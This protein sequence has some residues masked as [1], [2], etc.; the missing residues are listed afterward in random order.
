MRALRRHFG[1]F[2]CAHWFALAALRYGFCSAKF[3]W[4]GCQKTGGRGNGMGKV[5]CIN[6]SRY[7]M[8]CGLIT[9]VHKLYSFCARCSRAGLQYLL[10]LDFL[11]FASAP[12]WLDTEHIAISRQ[13]RLNS[14]WH[15]QG[16]VSSGPE[17][18]IDLPQCLLK[19]MGSLILC[20]CTFTHHKQAGLSSRSIGDPTLP[21]QYRSCHIISLL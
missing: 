5:V 20:C 1:P 11:I 19:W 15:E 4:V 10:F 17:N 13:S 3:L 7:S 2:V 16:G 18:R 12:K 6:S 9:D 8:A 14:V 21:N